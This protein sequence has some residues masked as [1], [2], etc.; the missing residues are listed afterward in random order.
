MYLATGLRMD[1]ILFSG[2]KYKVTVY[3]GNVSG[4]GTDA[5]VYITMFGEN[6]ESGERIL[7][8]TKKPFQRGK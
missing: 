6:G 3:T 5:M 7:H 4:A 1:Y 2:A 8:S